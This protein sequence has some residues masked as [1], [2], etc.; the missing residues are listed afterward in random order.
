M[1]HSS[2]QMGAGKRL[3]N[4]TYVQIP[5]VIKKQKIYKSGCNKKFVAFIMFYILMSIRLIQSQRT[6]S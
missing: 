4:P 6:R 3:P 1:D 2:L 5:I